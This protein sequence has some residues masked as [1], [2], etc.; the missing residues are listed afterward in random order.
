MKRIG[1]VLSLIALGAVPAARAQRPLDHDA[2]EIWRTIDDEVLSRDGRWVAYALT[3]ERRDP[4]LRVRSARDEMEFTVE[5]GREPAF[6]PDGRFVIFDIKPSVDSVRAAKRAKAKPEDMPKDSLGILDLTTGEITRVPR[7]RSFRVPEDAGAWVAY[8]LERAAATDP[9]SAVGDTTVV[10]AADTTMKP[11][12]DSD[13]GTTL[14]LRNLDSGEERRYDDVSDYRFTDSG[15]R[16]ALT[17]S[18]RMGDEDGV[19][20]LSLGDEIDALRVAAG[21]GD[22]RSPRFDDAGRQLAFLTDRDEIENEYPRYALYAWRV[23]SNDARRVAALGSDGMPTGWTVSERRGPT[24]SDSGERLYFGTAPWVEPAPEDSTLEEDRISVDIWHWQ[25]AVLQPEQLVRADRERRRSYLAVVHLGRDRVV[26]L[27]RLD[28]REVRQDNG[29]ASFVIGESEM[30]Y[31]IE[32][33]WDFPTYRDLYAINVRTGDRRLMAERV[34]DRGF[35]SPNGRYVLWFDREVN[36][37]MTRPTDGGPAVNASAGIPFPLYNEDHDTPSPANPY[38]WELWSADSRWVVIYDR[39]DMWAID[40]RGRE[41]PRNLTEGVGRRDRIRFRYVPLER[42][43]QSISPD[44][45]MLLSAFDDRDKRAGFYRDRFRGSDAPEQLVLSAHRYSR[46]TKAADGEVVLYTRQSVADFPNLWVADLDF[47]RA[48][49][50]TDANPQQSEYRWAA[51]ELIEWRSD[52]G[53]PLQGLLYKPDDFDPSRQYP[54]MVYFYERSSQNLYTHYQPYAHRSVIRPTFYASRGYIV[55]IPDIVYRTGYPG[56]SALDAVIPG[57]QEVLRRGFVDPDRI[58]VQGHSWGGYQIAY[59]VTRTNIFRAAAAGAPVANMT[60]AYGGIRWGSG[61]S[62]MFQ[63]ERTQSRIGGSLWEYP[64]RYIENSPVFWADRV[65][66]PLLMMHNDKDTAV[67][68]EQGIEMF[69]ALRRLGKPAWL[70]NYNDEPHWP[71]PFP[72]RRDWNIR[73]QQFFDYYLMDAPAPRWL[74]EGI[75]ATEKGRTL[76]LELVETDHR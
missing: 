63:Y 5:R 73:M 18:S 56:Q 66:T 62:R 3:L 45:P 23:G 19:V 75:P 39:Y 14:V 31:L 8:H 40:P 46:P 21:R 54:M 9:D 43:Q 17:L 11:K 44:E 34:Q 29:D 2:Y 51:V 12:K 49:Q 1:L 64:L 27:G 65:E 16:L 57:V 37:W 10:A 67:P 72:K 59:M 26:Q 36:A 22:Y 47:A 41:A 55:F 52:N 7:V 70:V 38:G 76:G 15:S 53:T 20:V 28:M 13:V 71:L 61:R 4:E 35:V 30:P 25:D 60:S 24:F 32:R 69:V 42:E 33:S 68:W 48:H 6:S 50:V 58:G 74:V